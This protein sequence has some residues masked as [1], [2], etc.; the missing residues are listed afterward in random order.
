MG[1]GHRH[2]SVLDLDLGA[3]CM[4]WDGYHPE[5][6]YR[7]GRSSA[8]T[9][10]AR[11]SLLL[12]LKPTAAVFARRW[13]ARFD[14]AALMRS[15][16]LIVL[17]YP[18]AL[19]SESESWNVRQLGLVDKISFH[20]HLVRTCRSHRQMMTRQEPWFRPERPHRCRVALNPAV[21]RGP[22]D[23]VECSG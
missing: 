4:D 1:L 21:L 6:V 16:G 2:A 20:R 18:A 12:A 11:Q 17:G 8:S 14:G 23:P 13:F 3:E 19:H 15:P 10:C 22:A 5:R 9:R 7:R